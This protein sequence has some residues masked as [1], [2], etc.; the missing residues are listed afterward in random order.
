MIDR[1]Y[2]Q[3]RDSTSYQPS[4]RPYYGNCGRYSAPLEV[5]VGRES[6]QGAMSPCAHSHEAAEGGVV[7]E[8]ADVVF[9]PHNFMF[10]CK[11]N[12]GEG[13]VCSWWNEKS[14]PCVAA[15]ARRAPC[16]V[17]RERMYEQV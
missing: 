2:R 12:I 10:M 6:S 13:G 11:L 5:T 9:A 1:Q 7:R 17:V 14:A 3:S 15:R 8:D 4:N 16:L